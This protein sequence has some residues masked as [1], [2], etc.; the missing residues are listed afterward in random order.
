VTDAPA[1]GP[2]RR[3]SSGGPWEA[4]YGYSRAIVA[5]D[6][7]HVSGTTDADPEGR[8]RHPGHAAAQARASLEIIER[9]LTEAGFTRHD[10][11]RTRIYLTNL[12]DAAVVGEVHGEWFRDVRPASSLVIV[13]ALID[14]TI[15]VEI[16]ADAQRSR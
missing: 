3:V 6:A 4:R 2:R 12:A 7:C 15:V 10:V 11:V 16:E 9:A 13:A 5:G 14:P 1:T 8:S